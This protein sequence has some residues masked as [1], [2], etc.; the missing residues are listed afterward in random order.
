MLSQVN[1]I[2]LGHY[3]TEHQQAAVGLAIMMQNCVAINTAFGLLGA[4]DTLV[5]QSYGAGDYELCCT[6]LQRGRAITAIQLVWQVRI[7]ELRRGC[8]DRGGTVGSQCFT[9][10]ERQS[11]RLSAVATSCRALTS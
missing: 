2:F 9:T 11:P 3:G 4:L 7:P 8:K 1:T 6:H 5:S 10:S